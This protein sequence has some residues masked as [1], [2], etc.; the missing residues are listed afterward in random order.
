MNVHRVS[1]MIALIVAAI[2]LLFAVDV[3]ATT[4]YAT[5]VKQEKMFSAA[6]WSRLVKA[7][8]RHKRLSDKNSAIEPHKPLDLTMPFKTGQDTDVKRPMNGLQ[9]KS[10]SSL[11]DNGNKQTAVQVKGQFVMSQEPEVD[12]RKSADGAGIS[13]NLRR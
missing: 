7:K 8:H 11:F 13:I 2:V 3:S 12:K 1:G 5:A 10:G 9:E 6:R 4:Y